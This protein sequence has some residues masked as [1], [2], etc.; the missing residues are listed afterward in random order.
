[1]CAEDRRHFNRRTAPFPPI[2]S[3]AQTI[4]HRCPHRSSDDGEVCAVNRGQWCSRATEPWRD[5]I[6]TVDKNVSQVWR[7]LH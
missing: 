3:A 7:W 2:L 1:M 4:F 6:R 5:L